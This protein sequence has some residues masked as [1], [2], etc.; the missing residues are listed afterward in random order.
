MQ[1]DLRVEARVVR[2]HAV[3]DVTVLQFFLVVIVVSKESNVMT[4]DT[5]NYITWSVIMSETF[6]LTLT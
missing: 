6:D 2:R 5:C 3:L 1:V 4:D